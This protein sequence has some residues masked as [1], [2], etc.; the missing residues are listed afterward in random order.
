M[1]VNYILHFKWVRRAFQFKYFSINGSA[2]NGIGNNIYIHTHLDCTH[3]FMHATNIL[4]GRNNLYLKNILHEQAVGTP[5]R[6]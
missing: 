6:L 3:I 2:N 1:H 4:A 5:P